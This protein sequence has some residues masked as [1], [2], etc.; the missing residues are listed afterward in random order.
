[1][2]LRTCQ[3]STSG[4]PP[5]SR[6]QSSRRVSSV[7]AAYPAPRAPELNFAAQPLT[8]LPTT[9]SR[10]PSMSHSYKAEYPAGAS[11]DP[12]IVQ[13]LQDFYAVSDVPGEHDRYVD[14]LTEDATFIM[15]SKRAR[16]RD[17]IL[18]VRKGMWTVVSSRRHTVFKVFPFAGADEFMIY[19][20]VALGLKNGAGVDVD[21][22][23]RAELE[24]SADGRWRMKYYQVYLDTGAIAAANK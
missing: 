15:A 19:G 3:P 9:S 20:S 8:I 4:Q 12:G 11:V 21:W 6:A 10:T 18:A 24:K 14:M 7:Q 17:E 23:A 1:M 13:F 22:A 2:T 5:A 16:G